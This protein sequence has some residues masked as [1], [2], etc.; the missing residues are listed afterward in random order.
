MRSG[1][2]VVGRACRSVALTR[3]LRVEW[4]SGKARCGERGRRLHACWGKGV[5]AASVTFVLR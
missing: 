5:R 1:S 3:E 4:G 2:A